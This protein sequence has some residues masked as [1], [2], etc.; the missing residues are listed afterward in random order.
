MFYHKLKPCTPFLCLSQ[1]SD[2]VD[3]VVSVSVYQPRGR[4]FNFKSG[5]GLEW[6]PLSSLGQLDSYMIKK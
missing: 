6:G 3:Q 5:L 4:A 1:S 2:L